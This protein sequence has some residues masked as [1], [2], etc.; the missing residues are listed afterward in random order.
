VAFALDVQHNHSHILVKA[1]CTNDVAVSV[2]WV[3]CKFY[4]NHTHVTL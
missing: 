1:V 3:A 2:Q 4:K